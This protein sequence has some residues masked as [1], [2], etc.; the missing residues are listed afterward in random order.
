[1]K[2]T[3]SENWR[4]LSIP[5]VAEILGTSERFVWGLISAGKIATIKLGRRRM[6]ESV[7][8]KEFV[9]RNKKGCRT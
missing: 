1:M 4:L 3:K 9:T 7:D 6:I 2:G 8:L 5:Q